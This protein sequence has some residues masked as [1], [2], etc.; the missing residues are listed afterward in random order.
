MPED[1]KHLLHDKVVSIFDLRAAREA[2]QLQPPLPAEAN[3]NPTE[4]MIYANLPFFMQRWSNSAVYGAVEIRIVR[5]SGVRMLD[6][7]CALYSAC[8]FLNDDLTIDFTLDPVLY[9]WT[10]DEECAYPVS[11]MPIMEREL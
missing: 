8:Y 4:R 5:V 3:L 1:F 2:A 10:S 6:L 9:D 11:P 7:D